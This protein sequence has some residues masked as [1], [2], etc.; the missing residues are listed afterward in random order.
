[1]TSAQLAHL[2]EQAACAASYFA[3]NEPAIAE[4]LSAQLA[5]Q[6]QNARLRADLADVKAQL[7]GPGVAS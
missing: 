5:R 2:A 6:E 7:A 1:M 4:R 3:A